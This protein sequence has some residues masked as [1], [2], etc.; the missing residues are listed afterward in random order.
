[1]FSEPTA[2][3][4]AKPSPIS[5]PLT[6]PIETSALERLASSFS[7]TGSP[8][9]AGTPMMRHS[10][11]PPEDSFSSIMRSTYSC[12]IAAASA[13]GRWNGLLSIS[14]GQNVLAVTGPIDE[15]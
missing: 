8:R 5:I 1:M 2:C 9:P 12:A 11:T 15:A 13:S 6:A 10:I 4:A 7:N 3:A 14:S